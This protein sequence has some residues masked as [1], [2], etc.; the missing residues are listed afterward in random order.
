MKVLLYLIIM[1]V[2]FYC[3]YILYQKI[4]VNET[5]TAATEQTA[6]VSSTTAA[7]PAASTG[8][9]ATVAGIVAPADATA[10]V[11]QST[12]RGPISQTKLMQRVKNINDQHNATVAK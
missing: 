4:F 3:G 2:V 8:S 10:I 6:T 12:S 11:S 5:A 9:I 1:G 7:S